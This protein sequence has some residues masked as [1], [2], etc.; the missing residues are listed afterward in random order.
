[1]LIDTHCHLDAAEFDSDRDA[2]IDQAQRDGVAAIVI[3]AVEAANFATVRSLAHRVPGGAY[4]LGIHPKY[5]DRALDS[6]L[7]R[8]REALEASRD[9]PKLVAVGE[10]GLD[11]FVPGLDRVR[12]QRFLEAQLRMAGA[13][14]LPVILH[15]RRAQD[16]ILASLRKNRVCG[17][18]A[19]AFNGSL[20]QANAYTNLG[21]ALGIGGA[22][23]DPRALRI[24]ALASELPLEALVLETDAPDIAPIWCRGQRNTPGELPC[25]AEV[26]AA[27]RVAPLASVIEG[28]GQT[29]CRVL[30]RLGRLQ[31]DCTG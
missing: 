14:E 12:Q 6:D 23:T 22:M 26:L 15:V 30:P 11:H 31:A 25:I 21:F 29:A 28:T 24:R 1:M 4:A 16:P 20:Q 17:G 9:D 3:P 10:I 7:E 8:L 5:V 2:V 13:F 27:L 19:H 18:I